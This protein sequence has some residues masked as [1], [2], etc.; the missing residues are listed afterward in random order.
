MGLPALLLL[1]TLLGRERPLALPAY[2]PA[3]GTQYPHAL[4]SNG[5]EFL[6]VWSGIDG[7]YAAVVD[8]HGATRPTPPHALF[9][10]N[11]VQAVWSGD[12][13]VLFWYDYERNATMSVRLSRDAELISQPVVVTDVATPVAI[14]A[15]D[16]NILLLVSSN[17][18]TT[19][20][21]LGPEGEVLRKGI[22]IP[23]AARPHAVSVV[24]S[25]GGFVVATVENSRYLAP[26]TTAR[27]T[28]ISVSGDVEHSVKLA[29]GLPNWVNSVHAA[30]DG[31]RAG[32][33]FVARR[34]IPNGLQYLHA[35]TVDARTL[36]AT[37]HPP[38]AVV[39]D[40]PQVVPTP[41][42]F[43]AGMLEYS[44]N[45][46]LLLT[47]IPFGSDVRRSTQ[48][49]SKPGADLRMASNGGTVMSVWRD[50]RFSPSYEYSTMNMFGLALD[51][52]AMEPESDVLPVAISAVA[53][54][55]PVI[56]SAGATSLVA[57]LD[58][59]KTVSGN[60]LALRVD[61]HG[62]MLERE[63]ITIA[64]DVT[65]QR[66]VVVFTGNVWIVAWEV[67]S[68]DGTST[69]SFMRRISAS[70][71]LLDAAP[72]LLSAGGGITAASNGT[73]TLL[74]VGTKVLRLS[75]AGE[76][77][78][79]TTLP[80]F[81][82][83]SQSLGSNGNEF[84]LA[85]NEGSDWW[86]FPSPNLLDIRAIRLDASGAP[87]DAVPIDIAMSESNE[88]APVVTS[89]GT[90]FLV[91]YG[92]QFEERTVRAKRVLRT[93]VLADHT[94]T[95]KGSLVG[96]GEGEFAAAPLD[97]GYFALFNRRL[98]PW[99]T[100]IETVS[101]DVRGAATEAPT[102]L[103]SS[104]RWPATSVATGAATGWIAYTRTVPDPVFANIERVFIR[105]LNGE[106]GRRRTLRN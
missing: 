53:Q 43:A 22:V 80:D 83:Y 101:L 76:L 66:P 75:S 13:Y 29:E 14:A 95:Q 86:Q 90:D 46:P 69:R 88:V 61:A 44:E 33:A 3:F 93:G 20:V 51:A 6:A 49:A 56:A 32:I 11:Y 104:D 42:G 77:L 35:F 8:E 58:L 103:A 89:N 45:A 12:A 5:T 47:T 52:T 17:D 82:G 87:M 70:G 25:G 21:L 68:A 78:G 26:S 96:E 74:T 23:T 38:K 41:G 37:V 10:A 31:D 55:Q 73:I 39:G 60:L 71:G 91:L 2:G 98:D 24:A 84:L 15:L 72:V 4:A 7:V 28:R 94:A 81:V 1:A 59:T 102:Q 64:A 54:A 57:W 34:T 99:K 100:V 48:I 40:D 9:S 16:R 27:A 19:A 106:G 67:R 105:T 18:T 65:M 36:V 97:D 62:R 79:T 63:P 30:S 50:Y 92:D 85:W